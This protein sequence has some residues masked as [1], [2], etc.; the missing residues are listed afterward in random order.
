M[1]TIA[2]PPLGPQSFAHHLHDEEFAE[3]RPAAETVQ[4]PEKSTSA[5]AGLTPVDWRCYKLGLPGRGQRGQYKAWTR[6]VT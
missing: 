4:R 3:S 6:A 5:R 2:R 1:I